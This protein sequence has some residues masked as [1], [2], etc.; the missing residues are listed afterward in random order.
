MNPLGPLNGKSFCTTISPWVITLEALAPFRTAIPSRNPSVEPPSYL[1]YQSETSKIATY[2]LDLFAEFLGSNTTRSTT[3]CHTKFSS[4]YWTLSDLV[5]QQTVNGCNLNVG[6][7]IA[8][9]TISGDSLSSRGCLMERP[10]GIECGTDSEGRP[11]VVKTLQNGDTLLLTGKAG[12]G[13]GFGECV[14][15]VLQYQVAI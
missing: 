6:D 7:L 15:T 9:G 5:A 13:V 2:D 14:G 12:E 10:D 4:L 8:T 1:H 11:N 3:L